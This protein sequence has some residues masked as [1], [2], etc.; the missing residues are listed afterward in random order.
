MVL[1]TP[2][3]YPRSAGRSSPRALYDPRE[4]GAVSCDPLLPP[5]AFRHGRSADCGRR[6]ARVLH[7]AHLP[8][9]AADTAHA[10]RAGPVHCGCIVAIW[11]SAECSGTVGALARGRITNPKF[12]SPKLK[13]PTFIS[14]KTV[15]KRGGIINSKIQTPMFIKKSKFVNSKTG[16]AMQG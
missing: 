8:M 5:V 1:P 10:S 3:R 4:V 14:L 12:K 6:G 11:S 7:M 2:L 13:C 15:G 9:T 16:Q